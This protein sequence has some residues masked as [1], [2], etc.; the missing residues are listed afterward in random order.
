MLRLA[1]FLLLILD[2]LLL[3]C[4]VLHQIFTDFIMAGHFK[5]PLSFSLTSISIIN[6][7]VVY[8]FLKFRLCS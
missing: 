1:T 4:N 2:E 6:I 5:F 8:L 3:F 7:F